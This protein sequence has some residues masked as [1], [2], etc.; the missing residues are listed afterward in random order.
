MIDHINRASL[1]G[2]FSSLTIL[3]AYFRHLGSL[4]GAM[5][6]NELSV[7]TNSTRL[8]QLFDNPINL[9]HNSFDYLLVHF[10]KVNLFSIRAISVFFAIA[11]IYSFY[12][13]LRTWFGSFISWIGTVFFAFTP[14]V[15]L[16]GRNGT[17]AILALFPL[18]L[19]ACYFWILRTKKPRLSQIIFLLILTALVLYTPGGLIILG[20]SA[21]AARKNLLNISKYLGSKK[22]FLCAL[23]FLVFLAPL[24]YGLVKSPDMAKTLVWWPSGH[25]PH[26]IDLLKNIGWN[27][28]AFFYRSSAHNDL[29][30]GRLAILNI[31]QIALAITGMYAMWSRARPKIYVIFA[32]SVIG[33]LASAFYQDYNVELVAIPGIAVLV[34]AGL[35]YMHIEWTTVFPRNPIPRGLALVLIFSLAIL[36]VAWGVRYSVYA[37]PHSVDVKKSYVVKY[38]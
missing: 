30:V 3:F 2:F 18:C 14:L 1:I 4:P 10:H 34:T 25:I 17:D 32:L 26:A 29:Q 11:I 31:A 19:V 16:A 38:Q 24:I 6:S 9:P 5:S 8:R 23:V 21:V 15:I 28:L 20:L 37:W 36:Q 7:L 33:I 13:I 27:F 12:T 22:V 35:R